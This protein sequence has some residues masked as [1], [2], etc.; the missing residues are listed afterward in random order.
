LSGSD[1]GDVPIKPLGIFSEARFDERIRRWQ[2][3]VVALGSH[4]AVWFALMSLG[5]GLILF[6]VRSGWWRL[7]PAVEI[8]LAGL[9]DLFGTESCS[10]NR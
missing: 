7:R 1:P 8:R 6:R 2:D 5:R 3:L 9:G 4:V 10:G